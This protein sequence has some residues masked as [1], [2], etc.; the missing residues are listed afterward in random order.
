MATPKAIIDTAVKYIGYLEK[1]SN[2]DLDDFTKNAGTNNYTKFNRDYLSYKIGNG[3]QPMEWCGAFVSCMFVYTFGLT[4]AKRLLC[5]NLHCYTPSGAQYFKNKGRYI[6]RGSGNPKTGDV[7]FFYSSEKKRIG[8]VGIVEK[9]S[10]N[11]VYTIEGNTSGANKLITNGGGVCRKSYKITS[12]YIDGYGRP[13]YDDGTNIIEK[14]DSGESVMELQS[15]LIKAGYALPKYGAD[16]DFGNETLEAVKAFQKAHGL[17]V[18]GVVNDKTLAALKGAQ[19][20]KRVIVNAS[21]VNVRSGAGIKNKIMFVARKNDEFEHVETLEDWYKI[22]KN[23]IEYY[24]SSK[25]SILK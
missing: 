17:T 21:K 4:E 14:G 5:G 22:R 18:D 3:A 25:Y 2:A 23:G 20:L 11:Y 7:I 6:P 16:G 12:T 13:P 10:G 24:I 15:L 8:H 1:K 19:G 9:V